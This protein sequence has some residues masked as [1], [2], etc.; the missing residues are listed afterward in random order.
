MNQCHQ[1]S[2]RRDDTTA[3]GRMTITDRNSGSRER[4]SIEEDAWLVVN[5]DLVQEEREGYH[6]NPTTMLENNAGGHDQ[7]GEVAP[8]RNSTTT[9]HP[10]DARILSYFEYG[11]I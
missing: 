5:N 10:K 1:G 6:Q 2:D 3:T 8:G 11:I 9:K 7:R 4:P